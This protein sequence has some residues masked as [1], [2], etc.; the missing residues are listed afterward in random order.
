LE[1]GLRRSGEIA[2]ARANAND[3]IGGVRQP[4]GRQRPRRADA[5]QRQR[6]I[7]AQTAFARH[8]FAYGDAV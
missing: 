2:V 5:A 6:V 4:I 3:E 7:V 1:R 8:R